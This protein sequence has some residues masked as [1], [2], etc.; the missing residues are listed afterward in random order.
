MHIETLL[1]SA[2][3]LFIEFLQIHLYS[4]H[5]TAAA[6]FVYFNVK[7]AVMVFESFCGVE[8]GYYYPWDTEVGGHGH[9]HGDGHGDKWRSCSVV[10]VAYAVGYGDL[11]HSKLVICSLFVIYLGVKLLTQIFYTTPYCD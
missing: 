11:F 6:V 5:F 1:L 2:F 8:W 9:G 3:V 7:L 4:E 10:K